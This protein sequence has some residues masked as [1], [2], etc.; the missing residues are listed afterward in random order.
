MTIDIETEN[1]ILSVGDEFLPPFAR[2]VRDGGEATP[3]YHAWLAAQVARM[4]AESA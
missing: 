3:E 2:T 4:S 1:Q